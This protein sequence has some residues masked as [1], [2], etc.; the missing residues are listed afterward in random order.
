M[1]SLFSSWVFWLICLVIN[2]FACIDQI[3]KT[4]KHFGDLEGRKLSGGSTSRR[5]VLL[6]FTFCLAV[7]SVVVLVV[8]LT[9]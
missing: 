2:G 1:P 4:L 8:V 9:A 3:P 6:I 7:A 5:L